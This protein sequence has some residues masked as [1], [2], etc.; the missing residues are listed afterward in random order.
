MRSGKKQINPDALSLSSGPPQAPE[1]Y[2]YARTDQS[3]AQTAQP[4]HPIFPDEASCLRLLG[5]LAVEIHE[6]WIKQNRY[7]NMELFREHKKLHL[8][9]TEAA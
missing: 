8:M 3:G 7:L 6:D 1:I 5:A 4:Y 9:K 2:E